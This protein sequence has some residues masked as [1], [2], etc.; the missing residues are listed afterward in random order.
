MPFLRAVFVGMDCLQDRSR[1]CSTARSQSFEH[2]QKTR[3][4]HQTT[5]L[6]DILFDEMVISRS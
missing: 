1:Y 4:A 2:T 6:T 3:I 5:T